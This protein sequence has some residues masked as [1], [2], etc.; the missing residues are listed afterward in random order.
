MEH[1]A[2]LSE[3]QND[4]WKREHTTHFSERGGTS[5]S[6]E[7]NNNKIMVTASKFEKTSETVL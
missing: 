1:A 4:L 6:Q 5:P 2:T 3:K 7:R